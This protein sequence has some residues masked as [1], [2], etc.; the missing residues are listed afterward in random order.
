MKKRQ[1]SHSSTR[2]LYEWLKLHLLYV[3]M[4]TV[5][6]HPQ[7]RILPVWWPSWQWS[8]VSFWNKIIS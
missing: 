6:V 8:V 3:H 7:H 1:K 4:Q 2:T 5:H